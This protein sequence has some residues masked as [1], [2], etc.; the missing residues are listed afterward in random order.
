MLPSYCL[1]RI[2]TVH[3]NKYLGTSWRRLARAVV[4]VNLRASALSSA[5]GASA[6]S[7]L[8]HWHILTLHVA[9]LHPLLGYQVHRVRRS[10][11][12]TKSLTSQMM[13][14]PRSCHFCVR[15]NL[16]CTRCEGSGPSKLS[17]RAT[18]GR[19]QVAGNVQGYSLRFL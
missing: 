7:R 5:C 4:F 3:P 9:V 2:K 14:K 18:P 17:R 12:T 1:T 15:E 8:P 6:R 19:I 16:Q 11:K 10:G 13:Q